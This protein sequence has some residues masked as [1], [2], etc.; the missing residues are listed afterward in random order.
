MD[1]FASKSLIII[2]NGLYST[3]FLQKYICY[4]LKEKAELFDYFLLSIVLL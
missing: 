4:Q 2:K 3:T 1:P